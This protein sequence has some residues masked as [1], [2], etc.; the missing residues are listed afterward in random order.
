MRG[1]RPHDLAA[2]VPPERLVDALVRNLAEA[3]G[4]GAELTVVASWP[5]RS[6]GRAG[7]SGDTVRETVAGG[8][9][10]LVAGPKRWGD[11]EHAILRETAAWLGL[12]ARLDRLRADHDRA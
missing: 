11:G 4:A 2:T 6:A 3:V 1:T 10:M 8:G 12:A 5:E 7:V 9:V